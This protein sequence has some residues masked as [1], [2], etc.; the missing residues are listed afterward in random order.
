MCIFPVL[1]HEGK[2]YLNKGQRFGHR[3]WKSSILILYPLDA[4]VEADIVQR[5]IVL[6]LCLLHALNL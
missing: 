3:S 4:L 6:Q 5:R 2:R 1:E